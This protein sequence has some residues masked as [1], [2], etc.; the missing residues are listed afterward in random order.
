MKR[1]LAVLIAVSWNAWALAQNGIPP[2]ATPKKDPFAGF[3]T[4]LDQRPGGKTVSPFNAL[5]HTNLPNAQTAPPNP[6]PAA[7]PGSLTGIVLAKEWSGHLTEGAGGQTMKMNDLQA[8]LSAYG[9]ADR[10]IDPHRDVTVYEGSPVDPAL[11]QKCRITYLMPLAQAERLL[12]KSRGIV[13]GG[14]AVAPGFPD[15][16]FMQV[17]EVRAGIYNRLIIL[18]DLAQ[19]VVSLEFK[20]EGVNYYPVSPPFT[21]L[22]RNWHTHDYMNTQNKGQPGLQ[23]DTRVNDLRSSGG[24]IV[25]NMTGGSLLPHLVQP[26][27]LKPARFSPK[28]TSTWY[29]PEPMISLILYT[30]SKQLGFADQTNPPSQ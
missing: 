6:A 2:D 23:I 5:P 13:T 14:R 26:V 12:F 25:V 27:V 22:E 17:Y 15:G 19:Q 3:G 28:E 20:A 21:K 8:L 18:T 30:L 7:A 1:Y 9:K 24:Y 11:G 4:S 10:D 29:L 16:L